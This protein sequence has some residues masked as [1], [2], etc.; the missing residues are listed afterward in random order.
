MEYRIL[1]K[2]DF[3]AFVS[4]LI[5]HH[6]VFGPTRK[7]N[8]YVYAPL[9][10]PDEL[11]LEFIR[12]VLPAKKFMFPPEETLFSYST[13][14][15]RFDV[16]EENM[17]EQI[18]IGPHPCDING[19]R[20]LDW[21]FEK[22]YQDSYY[23]RKR[24]KTRIIGTYCMPDKGCFCESVGHSNPVAGFDLFLIDFGIYFLVIVGTDKGAELLK[25]HAA[26]REATEEE[27]AKREEYERIR[28][29]QFTSKINTS[30]TTLPLLY[31][32]AFESVVW[33]ELG[34]ICLSCGHA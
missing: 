7:Y 18:L 5:D 2:D 3:T 23:L 28:S 9:Q 22:D 13:D 17:T 21:A 6:K 15:S 32:G 8:D 14:G 34:D 25:N 24:R 26:S 11:A 12:T 10:K 30:S 19:I 20:L 27:I 1:T 29:S 4:C 33:K 31:S 16:P